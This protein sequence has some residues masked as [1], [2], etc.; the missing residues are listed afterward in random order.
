MKA[1][2]LLGGLGAAGLGYALLPPLAR[3]AGLKR[4]SPGAVPGY[5]NIPG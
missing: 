3:A 4:E 1:S 2:P 5:V